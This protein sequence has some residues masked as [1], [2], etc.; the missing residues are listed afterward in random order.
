[1]IYKDIIFYYKK[2]STLNNLN[3]CYFKETKNILDIPFFY[4][5]NHEDKINTKELIKD[6]SKNIIIGDSFLLIIDFQRNFHHFMTEMVYLLSYYKN[7]SNF[8]LCIQK[9]TS[10]F[11]I[12]YINNIS[13]INKNNIIYLEEDINYLFKNIFI[14]TQNIKTNAKISLMMNV[15]SYLIKKDLDYYPEKIFIYRKNNK[16]RLA[17]IEKVIEIMKNNNFFIYSPE[18]SVLSTQYS[19]INY[20]KILVCELG[21]GCCN[22]FFTNPNVKIIILSFCNW[23]NKYLFFNNIT[24][25]DIKIIH[26]KILSGNEHSCEWIIDE[27][28]ILL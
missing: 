24:K 13:F 4:R 21:A 17:N 8:K 2:S 11:C 25:R 23:S 5:N 1:M 28:K 26:G 22:M 16:R 9:N 7:Y 20:C 19:L 12:E 15:N 3:I 14:F 10:K 18:E 27:N 6:I